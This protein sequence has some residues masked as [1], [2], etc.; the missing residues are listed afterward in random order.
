MPQYEEKKHGPIALIYQDGSPANVYDEKEDKRA[1]FI[2]PLLLSTETGSYGW[3]V[4]DLKSGACRQIFR[5]DI[6]DGVLTLDDLR[7]CLWIDQGLTK[8]SHESTGEA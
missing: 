8:A 7:R 2:A 1:S 3:A 5:R 4:P 6:A